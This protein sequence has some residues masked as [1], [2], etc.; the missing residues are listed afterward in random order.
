M[1]RVIMLIKCRLLSFDAIFFRGQLIGKIIE[2]IN[3]VRQL[4]LENFADGIY[5]WVK[6]LLC[7]VSRCGVGIEVLRS[8]GLPPRCPCKGPLYKVLG[9]ID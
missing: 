9:P 7:I 6:K 1:V 5:T 3:I 4:P 8:A 2:S